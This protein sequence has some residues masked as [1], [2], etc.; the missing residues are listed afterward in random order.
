MIKRSLLKESI[1]EVGKKIIT[2]FYSWGIGVFLMVGYSLF[3]LWLNKYNK[4]ILVIGSLAYLIATFFIVDIWWHYQ[5][6]SR[7][8]MFRKRPGSK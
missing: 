5:R 2:A 8:Q 6:I 3:I 4:Y 7:Q 1:V